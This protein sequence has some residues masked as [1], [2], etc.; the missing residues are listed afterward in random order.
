MSEEVKDEPECVWKLDTD[1][2]GKIEK[3][4]MFKGQ[5]AVSVCEQH[6]K[7]HKVIMALNAA[8]CDIDKVLAKGNEW[9]TKEFD[10]LVA[11][12]KIDPNKLET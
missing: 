11:A 5:I 9:R 2:G 3:V 6:L 8:G 4:K 1:C 12:G 7:E 10:S